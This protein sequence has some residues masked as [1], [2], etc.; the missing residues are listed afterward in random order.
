MADTIMGRFSTYSTAK[1]KAGKKYADTVASASQ[2]ANQTMTF[3]DKADFMKQV[4][5]K[6]R[7]QYDLDI[8]FEG[9]MPKK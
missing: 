3:S 6:A 5:E 7:K 4:K 8:F 1:R 2:K 9:G